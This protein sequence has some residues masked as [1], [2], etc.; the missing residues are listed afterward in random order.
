MTT[1]TNNFLRDAYCRQNV[2]D[3]KNDDKVHEHSLQ[4]YT[5]YNFGHFLPAA[6]R[7]G[8]AELIRFCCSC[9]WQDVWVKRGNFGFLVHGS[10]IICLFR[11]P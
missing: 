1:K 5:S 11:L 4:K 3:N 9:S 10:F 8:H 6:K 2:Y 7:H